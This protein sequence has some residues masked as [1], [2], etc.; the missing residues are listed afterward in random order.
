MVVM[1]SLTQYA[2]RYGLHAIVAVGI[3]AVGV[4]VARWAGNLAKRQL[5]RH[6]LEPPVRLL[7]VRV[8]RIIVLLFT[9]VIALEALGVPIAPLIAGI[10][11]AGV[12]I[13]LALQGVLSNVMAGLSIIFTKPY[14][15]GEHISLLGVHGDVVMIDIFSTVLMHSDRS[16]V[17]I[18]NRKIIGE[19][20]HNFG[21]IRQMTLTVNIAY[22]ADVDRALAITREILQRHPKILKDP[23][24]EVG[25]SVLGQPAVT[26]SIQPW[27][28]VVDY[29]STQGEVNK[30]VMERFRAAQIDFAPSAPAPRA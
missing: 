13:G 16:R 20:L 5:E 18:P 27:T 11:V 25:V 24:P 23:A 12:G 1:E 26:I 6:T 14:R 10:G 30:I 28:A 4:M 21:T 22:T 15:V 8:V 19:I 29:G 9:T 7:L 2:V 3:F 17:I